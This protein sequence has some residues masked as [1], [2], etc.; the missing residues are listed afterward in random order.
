MRQHT[1]HKT[2]KEFLA[3]NDWLAVEVLLMP[4]FP[5]V[6]VPER[7]FDPKV[8][9]H[10]LTHSLHLGSGEAEVEAGVGVCLCFWCWWLW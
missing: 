10:S 6:S 8:R 2:Y 7:L 3:L 1:I 4:G 9:S 5:E